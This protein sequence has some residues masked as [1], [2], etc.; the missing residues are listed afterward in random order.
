MIELAHLGPTTSADMLRAYLVDHDPR[1]LADDATFTDVTTGLSWTG[2]EAITRM[3][4]W[5]YHDVFE[6]HVEDPR[7]IVDADGA[8][9]VAEMTFVGTHRGEFG[10]VPASG[11][12]VRV[13]LVVIYDLSG[14]QIA[15]AR[16]HFSVASFIAQTRADR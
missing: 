9:G 8:I 11:R 3:L 5:M 16:V 7:V 14:G 6:A 1:H 10:G 2:R 4:T 15:G 13:P 12:D